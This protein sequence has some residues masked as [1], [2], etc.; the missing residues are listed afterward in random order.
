MLSSVTPF[1]IRDS[2]TDPIFIVF[3]AILIRYSR[4]SLSRYTTAFRCVCGVVA[5]WVQIAVAVWAV[6]LRAELM[7]LSRCSA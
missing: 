5:L 6:A 4:I 7:R 3:R 1:L 2:A